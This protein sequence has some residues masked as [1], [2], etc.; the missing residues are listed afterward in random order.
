MICNTSTY[1]INLTIHVLWITF[2]AFNI[3]NYFLT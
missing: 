1:A 3:S 2:K